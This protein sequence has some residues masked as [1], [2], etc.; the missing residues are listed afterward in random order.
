MQ[1]MNNDEL[2]LQEVENVS[3]SI[4][5]QDF[6]KAYLK[7]DSPTYGNAKRSALQVGYSEQT[8]D[9]ITGLGWFKRKMRRKSLL[10]KAEHVLDKTLDMKLENEEG[11]PDAALIRTVNDT[12]KFIAKTLG[13]DEGYTERHET[14][15]KDGNPIVFM[16][17]ELLEKFNLGDVKI[18]DIKTS[19]VETEEINEEE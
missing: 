17:A 16:P 18:E 14:T 13:K 7:S 12:A 9:C 11:K 19:E 6:W 3:F 1:H 8:S 2:E 5:Q 15:G 4:R 10:N